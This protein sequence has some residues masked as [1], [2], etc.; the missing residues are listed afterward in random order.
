MKSTA[1]NFVPFGRAEF[2]KQAK[3]RESDGEKHFGSDQI[4]GIESFDDLT[5]IGEGTYGKVFKARLA[6][7]SKNSSKQDQN[8]DL[9]ALK[10]LK[11]SE[12][13]EGFPITSLRE[14][15]ILKNLRHKNVVQLL[16]VFLVKK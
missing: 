13:Q 1:E 8:A 11:L 16:D 2:F 4:H 5:V 15:L 7:N 10:L 3:R 14:I 12:E 9:R 6:T